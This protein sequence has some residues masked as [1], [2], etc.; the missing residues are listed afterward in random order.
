MHIEV[1]DKD[2]RNVIRRKTPPLILASMDGRN[3]AIT[4]RSVP[5]TKQNWANI[6]MNHV[7]RSF[8]LLRLLEQR[9]V[10]RNAW[11]SKYRDT[12][13]SRLILAITTRNQNISRN[14]HRF[15][16]SS[17]KS[18][19]DREQMGFVA[20]QLDVPFELRTVRREASNVYV[21]DGETREID[22]RCVPG[23]AETVQGR[24]KFVMARLA[25]WELA[26]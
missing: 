18:L 22:G 1:A 8:E 6:R 14:R 23:F 5:N 7:P 26:N 24:N 17:Q 15:N 9:D 10:R 13:P 4:R 12:A 25:P 20:V 21:V 11:Q 3:F 2:G 16:G 19:I